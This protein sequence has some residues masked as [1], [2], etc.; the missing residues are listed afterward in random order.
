MTTAKSDRLDLRLT[1]SQKELIAEA[2]AL[3]G[4]SV[5]DFSTEALTER[6]RQ[7][8][9]EERQMLVDAAVFDKFRVALES[10]PMSVNGL[11]DLLTR[12]PIFVD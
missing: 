11:K 8:I 9:K 10:P 1:P 12:R 6:A 3:T 2:A 4:R 7:V 5:S